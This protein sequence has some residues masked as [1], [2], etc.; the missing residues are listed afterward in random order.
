MSIS[1]SSSN[2]GGK[3]ANS[4]HQRKNSYNSGSESEDERGKSLNGVSASNASKVG[5]FPLYD[6]RVCEPRTKRTER[7][8]YNYGNSVSFNDNQG[9]NYGLSSSNSRSYAAYGNGSFITRRDG[10]KTR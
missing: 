1:G 8:S 9:R 3:A 5:T 10:D 2:N 6:K 4:S 7:E